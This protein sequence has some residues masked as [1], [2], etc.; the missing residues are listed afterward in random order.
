MKRFQCPDCGLVW[1]YP[2]HYTNQV[3]KFKE[4]SS[5]WYGEDDRINTCPNCGHNPF[6]EFRW[7][8]QS[9]RPDANNY[10]RNYEDEKD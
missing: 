7:W 5:Y 4:N 10:W 3:D 1:F 9:W 8:L 6:P 2:L